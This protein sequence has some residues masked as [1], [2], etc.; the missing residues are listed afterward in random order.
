M[1]VNDTQPSLTHRLRLERFP[2]IRRFFAF[3]ALLANQ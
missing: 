3:S 2:Y 1:F